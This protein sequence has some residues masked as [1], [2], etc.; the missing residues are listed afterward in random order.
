[1]SNS[2]AKGQRLIVNG[3]AVNAFGCSGEFPE[4]VIFRAWKD[5]I[6]TEYPLEQNEAIWIAWLLL[7][8]LPKGFSRNPD[9][10]VTFISN[11]SAG[12]RHDGMTSG[13]SEC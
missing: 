3:K 10:L 2:N 7:S 8:R 12:V 13:V 11:S 6:L 1:M 4:G 9:D 5:G